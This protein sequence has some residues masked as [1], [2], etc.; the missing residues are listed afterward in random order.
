MEENEDL[1]LI[2]DL[3]GTIFR[4]KDTILPAVKDL[5]HELGCDKEIDTLVE[6][7]IG[8]KTSKFCKK[9]KPKEI[10][11]EEFTDKLWKKEKEFIDREGSLFEGIKEILDEL[12]LRDVDMIIC[13]NGNRDYIEYVL[14][15]FEL[16]NH[17]L[18]I[19]SGSDFDD[20]KDAVK[21]IINK[22]KRK[23]AILIGDRGID[24]RAA[25]ENNIPFIA[26]LY[27][28]GKDEVE[29]HYFAVKE[30]KGIL[31]H[32]NR[33]E[34]F[35][36]IE[37]CCRSLDEDKN[38]VIGVNG[39]DNSG[40]TTFSKSLSDYLKSRDHGT[41]II[42]LDDFHNPEEIRRKGDYPVD[43]YYEKAFGIERVIDEI[44]DPI[45]KNQKVHKELEILNLSKDIYDL[46]K[47]YYVNKNDIVIIEGV[48]L[49]RKPLETYIDYKIYLDINYET[50]MKRAKI[51]DE[52]RFT[53]NTIKRYK[54][55]YIPVQKKYI[56]EDNPKL[57]SDIIIDNNDYE[58]PKIMKFRG[59]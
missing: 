15:R 9:V 26:V 42:S 55:K 37:K 59:K 39:I 43:A 36:I 25:E 50:M 34:I 18:S 20:K 7:L 4:T 19:V 8:E 12:K 41:E 40:K 49:Y 3:D 46:K 29:S 30:P 11:I 44:L 5:L 52:N 22:N 56:K 45:R 16:E 35:S 38:I 27:G 10:D 23:N 6:S 57:K 17:F 24:M 58:K 33:F 53:E 14:S 48:L 13:S 1:L 21:H 2:F 54:R 32:I 51:R 47:E 28:Y 31:G